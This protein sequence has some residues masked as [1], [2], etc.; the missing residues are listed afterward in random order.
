MISFAKYDWQL[1]VAIDTVA[2]LVSFVMAM[3]SQYTSALN[4][5]YPSYLGLTLVNYL[6]AIMMFGASYLFHG[7][8]LDTD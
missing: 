7:A 1:R 6:I 8:S 3:F 5:D 2:I 4:K